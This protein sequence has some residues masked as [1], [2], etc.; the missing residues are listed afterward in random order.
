[1]ATIFSHAVAAA[2]LG[3]AFPPPKTPRFWLYG[4]LCSM[5]PDLDVIGFRFGIRYGDMLGHRGLTHS[6]AFAVVLSGIV[7]AAIFKMEPRMKWPALWLYFFLATIS[8]GVLDACTNGGLG[9][10]F[11]AP[12]ANTRYFFP[13]RPIRVSPI[14]SSFFSVRGIAVLKSEALWIW[15]PSLLFASAMWALCKFRKSVG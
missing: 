11:F 7:T 15:L 13:F 4:V 1:M 2:S 5:L 9:V 8:H 3:T 6:I 12:F 10:A 14:G